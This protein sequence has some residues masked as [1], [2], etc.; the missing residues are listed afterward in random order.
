[1]VLEQF[2]VDA[3]GHRVHPRADGH[4][5]RDQL[6][7]AV[8]VE[9]VTA[10]SRNIAYAVK[11]ADV[12]ILSPIQGKSAIG[13]EIPNTDRE[14]VSLG[15]V[16]RSPVRAA[17]TIR[18]WSGWARTS[19]AAR[20]SPTSRR[21][22][23]CLIPGATGAGGTHTWYPDSFAWRLDHHG[24]RSRS[25]TRFSMR[26]ASRVEVIAATPVMNDHPCFEVEFFDGTVIVA[27]AEHLWVTD[28]VAARGQ[29]SKRRARPA[30]LVRWQ[31]W[32]M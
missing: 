22:L 1:M 14:I 20:S 4:Q 32:P 27:D 18:W 30:I 28:T 25:G 7:P 24:S 26:T 23:I 17:T 10:L 13:M 16:L 15:D 6:G 29:R 31:R 8:K 19:R 9:R 5:V 2:E 11:S 21:C 12:R 3:A